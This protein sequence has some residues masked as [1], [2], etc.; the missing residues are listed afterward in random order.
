[1]K[2]HTIE[3]AKLADYAGGR[4][5]MIEVE[6]TYQFGEKTIPTHKRHVFHR[7]NSV[8]VFAM[9]RGKLVLIEQFRSGP[10]VAGLDPWTIEPIAGSVENGEDPIECAKREVVEEAPGVIIYDIT[11][12][13]RFMPSPGGSSE[14]IDL[15]MAECDLTHVERYG[16][17]DS[18]HEY[19]KI[20]VVDVST[21][22]MW[23]N[24]GKITSSLAIIGLQW[25]AL[26]QKK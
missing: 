3:T 25:I 2:S 23:L 10:A 13:C 11:H 8:G 19:I 22:M 18:E 6:Q 5:S 12:M 1:M 4:F 16:G 7:G 15:Y 24:T 17:L 26:N 9:D 21:A 20:H 14:V